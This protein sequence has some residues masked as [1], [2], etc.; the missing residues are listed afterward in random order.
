MDHPLAC[1]IDGGIDAELPLMVRP[2]GESAAE[3]SLA[4]LCRTLK[5][6]ED[7]LQAQLVRHGALLFRGFAIDGPEDFEQLARAIDDDLKNEYLGTSPRDAVTGHVFSAS[8]LP[9]FYPIPQHCEM[10]FCASPPRRVFFCCLV[11][12]QAGSGETPLCDFRKVWRDLEPAVLDRFVSRGIRH[13]R[14]YA[15]PGQQG[16]AMQLK[17]W[18]EMFL[19]RDK[20]VVAARAREEGFEPEWTEGDGLRLVSTQ[21]VHRDHPVTGERVWHN[22]A[23][24]FHVSTPL[25]EYRRI[26]EYR[27]SDRHRGLVKIAEKLDTEARAKPSDERSMHTTHLDGGEIAESDMEAVR[28]AVWKNL[29]VTPWQRGDV[30]AIDNHSTSHGRLPYEGDRKIVVCWS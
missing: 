26:A 28:D 14:N 21:P 22:H 27:P 4:A 7:W 5:S 8:E 20:A 13:V 18:D 25:A 12:P 6:N 10:S 19:T 11:E 29:S 24:T 16:D 17:G 23:T 9:D 2:R 3:R 30:V 1:R 15:A